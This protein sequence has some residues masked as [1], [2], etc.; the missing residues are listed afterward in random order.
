MDLKYVPLLC[1]R[2]HPVSGVMQIEVN[3][4]KLRNRNAELSIKTQQ[5]LCSGAVSVQVFSV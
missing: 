2:V 5:A 1:E 4:K 3:A